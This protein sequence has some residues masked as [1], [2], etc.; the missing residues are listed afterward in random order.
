[1]P[2]DQ[3]ESPESI[4]RLAQEYRAPR[5]RLRAWRLHRILTQQ[6]LADRA[7][8]GRRTVAAIEAGTVEPRPATVRALARALKTTPERLRADPPS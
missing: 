8:V 7:E 5:F 6:E 3:G 1:M 4:P 2:G